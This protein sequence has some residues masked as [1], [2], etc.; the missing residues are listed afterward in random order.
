[1]PFRPEQKL[2]LAGL[3]LMLIAPALL[4]LLWAVD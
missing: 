4:Y 2:V 3:A 1:M